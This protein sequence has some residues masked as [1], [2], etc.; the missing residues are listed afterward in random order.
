M[1]IDKKQVDAGGWIESFED[2]VSWIAELGDTRGLTLPA[3]GS[4]QAVRVVC[5]PRPWPVIHFRRASSG[6]LRRFRR[7]ERSNKTVVRAL[8]PGELESPAWHTLSFI[9]VGGA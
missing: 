2:F 6:E 9:P 1:I 4:G 5:I 3:W 8:A 7:L